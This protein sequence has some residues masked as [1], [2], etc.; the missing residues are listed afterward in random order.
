MQAMLRYAGELKVSKYNQKKTE[1]TG[2]PANQKVAVG[3]D[4]AWEAKCPSAL[5]GQVSH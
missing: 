5:P 2:F 4:I 3:S 1:K